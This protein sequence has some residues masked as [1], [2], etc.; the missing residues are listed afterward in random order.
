MMDHCRCRPCTDAVADYERARRRRHA[1]GR[2]PLVSTELVKAYLLQCP[3]LDA[4]DA[5]YARAAAGGQP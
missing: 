1:Y 5:T 2:S 4:V 3:E